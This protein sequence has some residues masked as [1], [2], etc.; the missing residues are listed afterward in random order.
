MEWVVVAALA[1]FV[2]GLLLGIWLFSRS[3]DVSHKKK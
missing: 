2:L 1:I 3:L